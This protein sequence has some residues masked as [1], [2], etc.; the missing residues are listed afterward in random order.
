M[1]LKEIAKLA[2]QKYDWKIICEKMDIIYRKLNN[3][4]ITPIYG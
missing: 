2:K 1:Y 3:K 4:K